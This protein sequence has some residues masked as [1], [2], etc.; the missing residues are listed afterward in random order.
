MVY[1]A[2]AH[3]YHSTRYLLNDVRGARNFVKAHF[4][5]EYAASSDPWD[6]LRD[7][8]AAER[9]Q[10]ILAMLGERRFQ[11]LLEVGCAAGW[12]TT[13]FARR[14]D[15]VLAV[16]IS[17]LALDLARNRC[18]HQPNVVF[19]RLDVLTDPIEGSYDAIVCAGVLV[20]VP[21]RSQ[22]RLRDQIVRLLVP[23]GCLLLEHTREKFPGEAAGK[24]IHALYASHGDLRTLRAER[25]D[26]YE[27]LLLERK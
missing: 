11:R 12:L 16:D 21:W 8:V 20:Y 14:A 27:V 9:K 5:A 3:A 18:R 24:A 22:R 10:L 4:D 7:P 26:I 19:R 13:E 15:S 2:G 17:E 6:Y 1:D 23:A 25:R